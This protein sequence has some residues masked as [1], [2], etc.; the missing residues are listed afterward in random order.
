MRLSAVENRVVVNRERVA[1][2]EI[3]HAGLGEGF[4]KIRALNRA[5]VIPRRHA[6]S[7]FSRKFGKMHR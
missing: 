2:P 6:S 5:P 7:L 1:A 3:A 4:P